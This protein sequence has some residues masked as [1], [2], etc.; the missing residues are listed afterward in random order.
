MNDTHVSPASAGRFQQVCLYIERHLDKPLSLE[1]LSAIAHSSPYHFHRQFSAYSGVPL[2]RYIQWL[3][4]RRACWRLAFNPQEK[5]I[6]IALD[7]GFQNPES[8]SRAFR[9]AFA[10]SPSQF[11]QQPDWLE[12]HRRVP[13]HTLQEQYPMDVN[14]IQLPTTQVA[15]LRHRGSPDLVN[16]TAG[17]FIAW[18]KASGLSPVASCETWGV[19]WDDPAATPAEDF[20]FD[21]CGT[22]NQAVPE[23]AFG[24]VNGE[25]PGGRCAVVRH[26]GSLDT[27]AQ[28]IW[29]LYRDWLP[30]SGESLR[31]FPVFFRYLNFVHEVGEHELQTDVYLPLN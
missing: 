4:L 8:F 27:L 13:K 21:I 31:D 25:I 26:H 16:E 17:K 19:S 29:F 12:W 5:I 2:Y 3:R 14:I 20:C 1:T 9:S 10:Q 28:S 24:V 7:A 6:D 22:V 11:R 15:M 18:R 23:N 30:A